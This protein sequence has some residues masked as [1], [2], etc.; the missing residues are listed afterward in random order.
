MYSR[1]VI[2][3][4]NVWIGF[5]DAQKNEPTYIL[6]DVTLKVHEGDFL[7]ITGPTGSGKTLLLYTMS[8][9][10]T[11]LKGDVFIYTMKLNTMSE[12][13]KAYLRAEYIGFVF[14]DFNLISSFNVVE[15]ILFPAELINENVDESY[16]KKL[17][18]K[19]NLN[20]KESLF[21]YQLSGG[22]RQRVA[23][24][25]ALINNPPILLVDEPTSNLDEKN[26]ELIKNI[27]QEL[28][29]SG[30]TIVL[31]SHDKELLQLSDKIITIKEGRLIE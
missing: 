27:L 3:L 1:P 25:R 28:K 19:F 6:R 8:G 9:I 17:I 18:D 20:G 21:P 29:E 12:E 2:Y 16:A 30:K 4:R 10:I 22:E 13:A 15:N 26:R 23:F 14:Q 5:K 11:P 7:A 24:A 31:V